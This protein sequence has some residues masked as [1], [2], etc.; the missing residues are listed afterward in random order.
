MNYIWEA[1]IKAIQ[2]NISGISIHYKFVEP[3]SPYRELSFDDINEGR[4][5]TE[6]E[7]NPF[8]RYH[9]IFHS[10]LEPNLKDYKGL[11]GAIFALERVQPLSI[12]QGISI[13]ANKEEVIRQRFSGKYPEFTASGRPAKELADLVNI[14]EVVTLLKFLEDTP[15]IHSPEILSGIE[16]FKFEA[17]LEIEIEKTIEHNEK[18]IEGST[19]TEHSHREVEVIALDELN[20]YLVGKN[21]HSV[22]FFEAFRDIILDTTLHHL[23]D[24]D[25]LMGMNKREYHIQFIIQDMYSGYF[26]EYIKRNMDCLAKA[27]QRLVANNLLALYNTAENIYLL[28][29]TIRR[30]FTNAYIFSNAEE[31]DEIVFW[32]RTNKTAAKQAKIEILKY[33]FLPFKAN[34]LIYW[35][36]IFGVM[37]ND[38]MM[39]MGRIVNYQ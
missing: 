5:L 38:E 39:R 33:L 2:M 31:K 14:V 17:L 7:V 25:V 32:L 4:I 15:H 30:I 16:R 8:Y 27:E 34:I 29:D 26:G 20:S 18:V 12:K 23:K 19:I 24:I 6:I 1:A 36:N 35:E 21:H 37:G 22:A 11:Q 13:P 10:L 3:F 9:H 28:K